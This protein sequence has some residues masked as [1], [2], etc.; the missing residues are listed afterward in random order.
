MA[1][2]LGIAPPHSCVVRARIIV[3]RFPRDASPDSDRWPDG[4]SYTRYVPRADRL[5]VRVGHVRPSFAIHG[6][7]I[8]FGVVIAAFFPFFTLFLKERA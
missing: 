7:F 1:R 6:L 5:S 4:V 2:V 8:L 3:G